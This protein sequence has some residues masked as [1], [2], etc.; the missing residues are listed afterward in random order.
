MDEYVLEFGNKKYPLVF[1]KGDWFDLFFRLNATKMLSYVK[2]NRKAEQNYL[3]TEED[4]AG[5]FQYQL[6]NKEFKN[7]QEFYNKIQKE[8]DDSKKYLSKFSTSEN[9]GLSNEFKEYRKQL[10]A[11]KFISN[12]ENYRKISDAAAAPEELM[13]ELQNTVKIRYAF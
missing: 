9:F 1:G 8:W 10:L 6:D 3:D 4:F 13:N 11:I 2:S 12:I 7:P 5:N